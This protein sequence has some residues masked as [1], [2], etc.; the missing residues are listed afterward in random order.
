MVVHSLPCC[1]S[2]R[3]GRIKACW[4]IVSPSSA[5]PP[6]PL[7]ATT[8]T[9]SSTTTNHRNAEDANGSTA[10]TSK[11]PPRRIKLVGSQIDDDDGGGAKK[12]SH[13]KK[14]KQRQQ[15]QQ[16]TAPRGWEYRI[17]QLQQFYDEKGH[18][19]V[20][21]RHED[22]FPGL[23][24]W[25]R[26]VRSRYRHQQI[27]MM[28][29]AEDD[30][31]GDSHTAPNNSSEK[32]DETATTTQRWW[33]SDDQ[34]QQLVDLDFVWDAQ[35]AAWNRRLDELRR[36]HAEWGHCRVP[37]NSLEFPG[38]GVWVRNQ[39][40]EHAKLTAV[41]GG[42]QLDPD[43]QPQKSSSRS[44]LTPS[45]LQALQELDFEW[46]RSHQDAWQ[47][48]YEQLVAYY[49]RHGHSNVPQPQTQYYDKQRED[50]DGDDDRSTAA[51]AAAGHTASIMAEEQLGH[52]CMNQRTA[53][54]NYCKAD[55]STNPSAVG[56]DRGAHRKAAGSQLSVELAT[57]QVA[58]HAGTTPTISPKARPRQ[59]CGAGRGQQGSSPLA[60]FAAVPVQQQHRC[61]D[62]D[63]DENATRSSSSSSTVES[64]ATTTT[65][66]QPKKPASSTGT[67]P[68]LTEERIRAPR[69]G[70][71]EFCLEGAQRRRT[72]LQR[73][74]QTV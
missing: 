67:P 57:A 10:R 12:N 35:E 14:R 36:F 2:R 31:D 30:A 48:R 21:A 74:G 49:E 43:P 65:W 51:A 41:G 50:D 8:T 47:T 56:S 17:R 52:W 64:S 9:I 24:Q 44:T 19:L 38:L 6:Q 53:Y 5:A 62:D 34:W 16:A 13:S 23:Y 61:D 72:F 69:G 71:S 7:W 3:Q 63:D 42:G 20:A 39:R 1:S 15:Q 26:T 4:R 59:H 37:N 54:R 11:K 60:H 66:W 18:A 55:S 28:C 70:H 27:I 45:R 22:D 32:D 40:R 25:T 68:L 58:G 46:Y 33:L 29:K 73:L